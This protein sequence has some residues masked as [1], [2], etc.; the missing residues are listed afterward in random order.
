MSII[1]VKNT[2]SVKNNKLEK[3]KNKIY[4]MNR[5]E[6]SLLKKIII[7]GTIIDFYYFSCTIYY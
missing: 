5:I 4:N 6:M 3:T 2:K 1:K 7:K